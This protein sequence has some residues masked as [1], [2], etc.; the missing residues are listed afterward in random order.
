[1]RPLQ[2]VLSRLPKEEREEVEARARE[3]ITEE[4]TLRELRQA[5]DLTQDQIGEML[6]VGQDSISRLEKRSDL[7]LST[8][9]SYVRAMG[10]SLEL[11]VKFPDHRPDVVLSG[12][13]TSERDPKRQRSHPAR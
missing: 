4:M 13:G 2:E 1:M 12:I 5:C 9:R 3:L 7:R 8:L 6:K 11:T 10:G